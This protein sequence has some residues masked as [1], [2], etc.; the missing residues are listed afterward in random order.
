MTLARLAFPG[1]GPSK[2]GRKLTDEIL[3]SDEALQWLVVRTASRRERDAEAGL[4]EAGF[5]VYVPRLIRWQR[6]SRDRKRVEQPLFV[7]YLFAGL[8]PWQSVMALEAVE[9][10]HGVVRFG[11]ERA[12]ADVA[13]SEVRKFLKLER[14][15]KFD[16]TR[17]RK[18]PEPGAPIG[19]VAGPFEGHVVSFL[20]RRSDERIE[21]LRAMF[22]RQ[23]VLVL[24]EEDVDGMGEGRE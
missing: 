16:K 15:G 10:V 2:S 8:Q 4:I 23:T 3:P 22:G 12:P 18:D 6:T 7:G 19:I 21:V 5:V 9:R 24:N 1:E 20:G 13:Y 14:S 11:P 17:K